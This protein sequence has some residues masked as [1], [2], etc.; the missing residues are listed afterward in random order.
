MKPVVPDKKSSEN[1]AVAEL[2]TATIKAAERYR[3]RVCT[4]EI[5]EAFSSQ[6]EEAA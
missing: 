6:S 3:V 2:P 5:P 1:I 4:C